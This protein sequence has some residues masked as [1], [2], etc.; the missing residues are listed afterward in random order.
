MAKLRHKEEII[1]GQTGEVKTITKTFSVK[2]KNKEEFY[3]T[4][5]SGLNAICNLS[6]PN[7]IK[8]LALMCAKAEFNT[9]IVALS[10]GDRREIT[11]KLGFSNQSFSNSIRRLKEAGLMSGE[12]GDYE[13][14]PHYFWKGTTDERNRLLRDK[15]IDITLKYKIDDKI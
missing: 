8:V 6:R 9:G 5:L 12:R 3:F 14:N 15:K 11:A 2:V 10:A 13:I 1:D 4:F 7:D